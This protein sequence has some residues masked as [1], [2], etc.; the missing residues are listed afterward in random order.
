MYNAEPTYEYSW[1]VPYT[2]FPTLTV[3][4]T[5][6]QKALP[7]K[8]PC[9]NSIMTS[10]SIPHLSRDRYCDIIHFFASRPWQHDTHRD[11]QIQQKSIMTNTTVGTQGRRFMY[12]A[13][14]FS[15]QDEILH[16]L[17]LAMYLANWCFSIYI[18]RCT[19]GC[20]QV[21]GS[22]HRQHMW[23]WLQN[24]VCWEVHIHDITLEGCIQLI[25][26]REI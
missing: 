3:L 17:S 2:A 19:M 9:W 16:A 24:D 13:S 26:P 4:P 25:G 7:T 12:T 21:P 8:R 15:N 23:L 14:N 6:F 20:S 11:G 18:Q 22:L 10:H 1:P 5:Y